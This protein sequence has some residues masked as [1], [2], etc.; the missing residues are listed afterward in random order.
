MRRAYRTGRV[1]YGGLG[2]AHIP[3]VD[4]R[5][6]NDDA[7]NGDIHV[8]YHSFSMRERLRK[9]NGSAD[10]QV[11]LVEDQR[12]GLYGTNSPLLQHA[13]LELDRWITAIQADPLHRIAA[14]R[15][16]GLRE[17]CNTRD[18]DPTFIAETQR[19]DASTRCEQLYPSASFP[20]E[21]A[22]EDVAADIVKCRL[23][24][25]DFADYRVEVHGR[26][27]R[28]PASGVPGRGVRL[29]A[30]RRLAAAAGRDLA[31]VLGSITAA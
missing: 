10:N 29:V 31:A 21:V 5:A 1:T 8:R 12:Y 17:G 6:Y 14:N 9:A 23:K 13:I 18:A 15:P 16:A 28:P 30:A 24:P 2:L 20:R 4:Y 22:G 27:A 3:I 26:A 25:L 19:R 7:P 11:M